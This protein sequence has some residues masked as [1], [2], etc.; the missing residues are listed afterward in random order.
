M[1]KKVKIIFILL[2]LITIIGSFCIIS[3]ADESDEINENL[4][5]YLDNLD[6]TDLQNYLDSHTELFLFNFGDNAKE[7]ITYLFEGNL[8]VDYASYLSE[9]FSVLFK[10]VIALIPSLSEIVALCILS[11]IIDNAQG[12]IIS[13]STSSIVKTICYSLILL[14]IISTLTSI[15]SSVQGCISNIKAQVEIILP[16]LVTL[17]VLCGGGS[18]EI[19][20][21]SALFL[22]GGAV[23]LVSSIIYPATIAVVILDALSKL[24]KNIS[25]SG[26]SKL[27][28]S[29]LKWTIGITVAVFSIFLTIQ[30]SASSIFNG[31]FF[32]ATKYLVGNSV[33]LVG[34]FLSSGVEMIVAAGAIIKSSVGLFGIILLISEVIQPIIMLLSLSIMLKIV[35][36]IVQPIGENQLYSLFSDLSSDIE[37]FIAGILTV[38][39]M[40]LLIIMLIINC[41]NS[42][43]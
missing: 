17:T 27:I 25:F 33:P 5:I 36:A 16:I 11:A 9:I 21:P 13:K 6:L 23:E 10:N 41:A 20:Q 34:G 4:Q 1:K 8:G 29:I 31:I 7:I 43:F 32:K 40:Y 19:Y 22:S 24:N 37:Y 35:G 18:A 14:L 30:S 38:V 15:I 28:K 3:Y 2:L 12:G 39:F 26:T 42:Y